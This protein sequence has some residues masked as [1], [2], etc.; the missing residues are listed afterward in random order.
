ML[1]VCDVYTIAQVY[2]LLLQASNIAKKHPTFSD[3]YNVP[4]IGTAIIWESPWTENM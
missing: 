1:W 2:T 3:I 4:D